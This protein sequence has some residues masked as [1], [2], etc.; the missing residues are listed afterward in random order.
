MDEPSLPP[1][2]ET[3]VFVKTRLEEE[4]GIVTCIVVI[5]VQLF[6]DVMKT[7]KPPTVTPVVVPV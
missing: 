6:A 2:H 3:I 4:K 5:Y 7:L 1:K